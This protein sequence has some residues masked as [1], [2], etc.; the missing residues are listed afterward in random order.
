MDS[1]DISGWHLTSGSGRQAV[2]GVPATK[3]WRTLSSPATGIQWADTGNRDRLAGCAACTSE[4]ATGGPDVRVNGAVWP[5]GILEAVPFPVLTSNRPPRRVA[6][7]DELLAGPR[8]VAVSMPAGGPHPVDD[9]RWHIAVSWTGPAANGTWW[10]TEVSA[11]TVCGG[12]VG[13]RPKSA[14]RQ[15]WSALGWWVQHRGRVAASH[16]GQVD[17]VTI[18][19]RA[20]APAWAAHGCKVCVA[21]LAAR[22]PLRWLGAPVDSPP[23]LFDPTGGLMSQMRSAARAGRRLAVASV[24]EED[25]RVIVDWPAHTDDGL[26]WITET[27]WVRQPLPSA[28]STFDPW[29]FR[30]AVPQTLRMAFWALLA[31]GLWVATTPWG[32]RSPSVLG[33]ERLNPSLAVLSAAG[34]FDTDGP[35]VDAVMADGDAATHLAVAGT[36]V[37][38]VRYGGRADTVLCGHPVAGDSDPGG[39]LCET[40]VATARSC[41]YGIGGVDPTI[42]LEVALELRRASASHRL[43]DVDVGPPEG[44]LKPSWVALQTDASPVHQ[45]DRQRSPI[46]LESGDS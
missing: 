32:P 5:A 20:A 43:A 40:C 34:P 45:L 27:V 35:W 12:P 38:G 30:R 6:V 11:R 23:L 46:D 4:A 31:D 9:D 16:H 17:R 37:D 41:G 2:C 3:V 10:E 1:F 19:T 8:P 28:P 14:P 24:R 44:I 36:V 7:P 15:V 22:W 42:P 21:V 26:R 39:E 33:H 25:D 29:G 13:P 18:G